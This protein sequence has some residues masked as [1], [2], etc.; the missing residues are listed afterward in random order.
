MP[1]EPRSRTTRYLS[2]TSSPMAG[3]RSKFAKLAFP[4]RSTSSGP[5]RAASLPRPQ[6]SGLDDSQ[7]G[8]LSPISAALP[9]GPT[10]EPP[11]R[12]APDLEIAPPLAC[13]ASELFRSH[14]SF[15]TF[16]RP[17]NSVIEL[18]RQSELL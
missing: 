9:P 15:P 16:R 13:A 12:P 1:P 7:R 11:A 10:R 3:S 14:L 18:L 2:T 5:R 8:G 6:H 4:I 17:V